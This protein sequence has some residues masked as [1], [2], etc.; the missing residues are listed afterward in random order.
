MRTTLLDRVTQACIHTKARL[1]ASRALFDIIEGTS[2]KCHQWAP[3]TRPLDYTPLPA[4]AIVWPDPVFCL[5]SLHSV[6]PDP[7]G[8]TLDVGHTGLGFDIWFRSLAWS[9]PGLLVFQRSLASFD[10]IPLVLNTPKL[11]LCVPEVHLQ[12]AYESGTGWTWGKVE[13]V[14]INTTMHDFMLGLMQPREQ[15]DVTQNVN[16]LALAIGQYLGAYAQWIRQPGHWQVVP[17]K[18][19]RVKEK[20]GVVKKV[21][22]YGS[23]GYKTFIPDRKESNACNS[24]CNAQ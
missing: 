4:H 1:P 24:A 23:A 3:W 10:V 21:Y 7:Y 16:D 15:R 22:S 5:E 17:S 20:N 11:N 13:G 6:V 12:Y 9:M 19:P 2:P 8:L 14:G 18:P